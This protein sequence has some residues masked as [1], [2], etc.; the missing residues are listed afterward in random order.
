M[1]NLSIVMFLIVM[2]YF[3]TPTV[4]MLCVMML[5]DI[6]LSGIMLGV[7]MIRV[8]FLILILS[9]VYVCNVVCQDTYRCYAVH[10]FVE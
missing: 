6:V 7:I 1:H 8:T 10:H 4:V 2:L 9:I 3:K 5:N